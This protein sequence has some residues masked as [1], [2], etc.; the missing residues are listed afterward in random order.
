MKSGS[1]TAWSGMVVAALFLSMHAMCAPPPVEAYGNAPVISGI[2]INPAGTRLAWIENNAKVTRI[3][4]FDLAG[5]RELQ[6]IPWPENNTL[7][8][9]TWADDETALVQAQVIGGFKHEKKELQRWFAIPVSTGK[10]QMLRPA[11]SSF[12]ADLFRSRTSRPGKI[13]MASEY[14]AQVVVDMGN[15]YK[16]YEVDLA[17]GAGKIFVDGDDSTCNWTVDATGEHVVRTDL[18]SNQGIRLLV[19][20]GSGWRRLYESEQCKGLEAI[21]ISADNTAVLALGHPC[22][23]LRDKLW[24]IPLDGSPMKVLIGD[25]SIDVEDVVTDPFDGAVLGARMAGSAHEIRWLDES[26]ERR[27]SAL[28]KSFGGDRVHISGRSAD[29]QKIVVRVDSAVKPPVYHLVDYTAKRADIIKEAYPALNDVKQGSV[30]EF[31]YKARD[32]YSLMAYLTI[33]ADKSEKNLPLVVLPHDGPAENDGEQFD[34]M[35][36]FLASRGYAVLQP[37]FRGS[38]GFGRAHAEAGMRQWGLLMQDDVTDA[39][40]AVIQQ[41]ITDQNRV[42]IAGVGYGGYVALAGA[43][44]TPELYACAA[45]ISGISNLGY[46]LSRRNYPTA[47]RVSDKNITEKS[48]VHSADTFRAPILLVHSTDDVV[49][50]MSQSRSMARALDFR[51]RP[52]KLVEIPGDDHWL[53]QSDTRIRVLTELERFLAIHLAPATN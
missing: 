5:K 34:W 29:G 32:G 44:F 51:Q 35:A 41:G 36:Q 3:V 31:A 30:R 33:P 18:N 25:P 7:L 16:L 19:K 48:P 43:A 52:Y 27:A 53:L 11:H 13:F 45:S 24:S 21:S 1:R 17:S 2:D 23:D 38:T 8:Y 46:F 6:S 49:I 28:R 9:V 37:Q 4:V 39:V 42:C 22:E 12:G 14:Q 47:G 15:S 40:K 10:P 20:Q 26:S 50:P